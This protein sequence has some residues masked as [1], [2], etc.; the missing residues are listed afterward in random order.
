MLLIILSHMFHKHRFAKVQRYRRELYQRFVGMQVLKKLLAICVF[1]PQAK[2]WEIEMPV[3]AQCLYP[4][5][6]D[7][8][9][10][11]QIT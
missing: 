1:V 4:L 7:A 11:F 5:A 2:Q 8:E 10:V 3:K 6:I 9:I